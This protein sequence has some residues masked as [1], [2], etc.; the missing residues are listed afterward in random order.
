LGLFGI[1]LLMTKLSLRSRRLSKQL[2]EAE[3]EV[4]KLRN[5]TLQ[6]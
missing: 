6:E 5:M 4:K 3:G 2:G 1:T